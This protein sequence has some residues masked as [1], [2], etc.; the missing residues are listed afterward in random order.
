MEWEKPS[1]VEINMSAEIGGYQEEEF[2]E[3]KPVSIDNSEQPRVRLEM[4]HDSSQCERMS[5][6]LAAK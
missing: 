4:D 2:Q 6:P 5:H 3:R 1:Y